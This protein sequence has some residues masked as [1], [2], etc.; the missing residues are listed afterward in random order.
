MKKRLAVVCADKEYEE[1]FI[2]YIRKKWQDVFVVVDATHET[3]VVITD[4][5]EMENAGVVYFLSASESDNRA[6]IYRY[7][8]A[9]GMLKELLYKSREAILPQHKGR[10]A[11][12]VI[13]YTPGGNE[14]QTLVAKEY[15]RHM[16]EKG[17]ALYLYYGDFGTPEEMGTDLSV[18]CYRIHTEG[19]ETIT[20]ETVMSAV[21]QE[22]GL[23]YLGYFHSPIHVTEMREEFT[24]LVQQL[25][26]LG[27]FEKIILDLNQLPI[28]FQDLLEKTSEL[29]CIAPT[30][31][32][33]RTLYRKRLQVWQTFI[34]SLD[35]QNADRMFKERE[36]HGSGTL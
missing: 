6:E 11:K 14:A 4:T 17:K 36:Y 29:Y 1:L 34:N 20:A 2:R 18:L 21:R 5:G 8:S 33:V 22:E 12:L 16:G 3:D 30:D 28:H 19:V 26:N 9:E 35:C 13:F 31:E 24:L 25:L 10:E 32:E 27:L 23:S 15:A 7:Q